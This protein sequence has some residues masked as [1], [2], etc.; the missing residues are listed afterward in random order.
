MVVEG[1][2]VLE[3]TEALGVLC[4]AVRAARRA[5]LTPRAD[6]V[7]ARL[8]G[9]ILPELGGGALAPESLG[10]TFEG[11]ALYLRALAG[12]RGLLLILE[13]LHW[14]DPTSLRLVPFLARAL[15]P[16]RTI[17]LLTYRPDDGPPRPPCRRCAG[18][19]AGPGSPRRSPSS[20]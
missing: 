3:L 17:M 19:C 9:H 7:A 5:G 20:R 16:A 8:S 6:P 14:A 15:T 13:D 12:G 4:D 11:A 10:A 18:S 2:A 1:R